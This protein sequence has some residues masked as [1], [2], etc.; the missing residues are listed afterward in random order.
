MRRTAIVVLLLFSMKEFYLKIYG[1]KVNQYYAEVVRSSLLQSGFV[2]RKNPCSRNILFACSVTETAEKQSELWVRKLKDRGE[3]MVGGCLG[4]RANEGK[5]ILDE[6]GINPQPYPTERIRARPTVLVQTGCRR[7]CSYCKVNLMRGCPRGRSFSEILEEVK[8][9]EDQ[10]YREVVLTG[11]SL[12]CYEHNIFK[13]I[14]LLLENTSELRFRLGSLNP[15]DLIENIDELNIFKH[16]RICNHIHLSLQSGSEQVLAQM[17]RKYSPGEV[18]HSLKYLR[19]VQEICLGLDVICGFPT[20]TGKNF[21]ETVSILEK[22]S[23][24]YLHVFPYSPRKGT[25]AALLEDKVGNQLRLNRARQIRLMAA[26]FRHDYSRRNLGKT[27]SVVV[28]TFGKS[29]LTGTSE[30][31]M[32]V[33]IVNYP[34]EVKIRQTVKVEINGMD[35]KN[36]IGIAPAI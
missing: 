15:Q 5:A 17:N 19:S 35:N 6:L 25:L 36:L 4:D 2:E 18:E 7:F 26:K 22:I 12:G 23:P 20:E 14:E 13:L 9:L 1:C 32:K 8:I 29:R 10:G 28:E 3:V 31:Y 30:N 11:I 34:G 16:S 24:S 27:L 21:Q 33:K